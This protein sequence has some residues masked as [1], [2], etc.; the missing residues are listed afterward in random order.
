MKTIDLWQLNPNI[1]ILHSTQDNKPA[2]CFD[3]MEQY[4]AFVVDRSILALLA[5]G[6]D[7]GQNNKGLLDMPTRSRIISKINE[8]WFATE[9]YRSGEKLFSDIM[10]LQTKDVRAFCCGKVKRIKFYTPKW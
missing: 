2:L 1:G 3:L 5:K 8:R 4:R 7:V 9:Y 6:E 10:K